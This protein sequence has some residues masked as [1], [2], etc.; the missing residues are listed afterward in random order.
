MTLANEIQPDEERTADI[1]PEGET[2]QFDQMMLRQEVHKGLSDCGYNLPSPI[3]V[4]AIPYARS[5]SGKF[6]FNLVFPNKLMIKINKQKHLFFFFFRH[7]NSVQIRH[8]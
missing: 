3:Q 4:I 6:F 2:I 5:E 8:R 7:P 1:L